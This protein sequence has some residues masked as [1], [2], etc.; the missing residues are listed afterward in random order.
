VRGLATTA[1]EDSSRA[2]GSEARGDG[3]RLRAEDDAEMCAVS[4]RL[5]CK[6]SKCAI[7]IGIRLLRKKGAVAES[8]IKAVNAYDRCV[9][10]KSREEQEVVS[11]A[12][13]LWADIH[14]A[15]AAMTREQ[16]L[17]V[18][19]QVRE[20]Q[21]EERLLWSGVFDLDHMSSAFEQ[22]REQRTDKQTRRDM[23]PLSHPLSHDV[24]DN[25]NHAIRYLIRSLQFC[26]ASGRRTDLTTKLASVYTQLG[27]HYI[28]MGRFTRAH[29]HLQQGTQLFQ[30]IGDE[31]SAASLSFK[32]GRLFAA[33]AHAAPIAA[34]LSA[35]QLTDL[36]KAR[37]L[38]QQA[39][40]TLHALAL[41]PLPAAPARAQKALKDLVSQTQEELADIDMA[42]GVGKLHATGG[43][44]GGGRAGSWVGKTGSSLVVGGGAGAGS[45][46]GEEEVLVEEESADKALLRALATYEALN[47]PQATAAHLHLALYMARVEGEAAAMAQGA[48]NTNGNA[49][50]GRAGALLSD[51]SITSTREQ[52]AAALRAVKTWRQ[53]SERHLQQAAALARTLAE[54]VRVGCIRA[55]L[56]VRRGTLVGLVTA[57]DSLLQLPEM[58]CKAPCRRLQSSSS[59][60]PPRNDGGAAHFGDAMAGVNA[61]LSGE[62]ARWA[63]FDGGWGASVPH[64]EAEA[65]G[66]AGQGS[67]A[68]ED[69]IWS[70]V[71]RQTKAVLLLL[72]RRKPP[73]QE[74]ERCKALFRYAL[75]LSQQHAGKRFMQLLAAH[76]AQVAKTAPRPADKDDDGAEEE[77][78]K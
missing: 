47:L 51:A 33:R 1:E 63:P 60:A 12:M 71:Q 69:A 28:R 44:A 31:Q 42:I 46:A 4:R 3:D 24:E 32:L 34:G 52:R 64:A 58:H 16:V 9:R 20:I 75:E 76:Y 68:E 61:R 56:C 6:A 18:R 74:G 49:A 39:Y 78:D 41:P 25:C 38:V 17:V 45:G 50:S 36:V 10:G 7:A 62:L 72:V 43:A 23:T 8:L 2:S 57:L 40:K 14:V 11:E 19:A 53:R 15:L 30:S 54:S 55:E 22:Q 35:E 67:C 29:Q 13:E 59:P 27:A 26:N 37:A 21:E 48:K 77:N 66:H 5:R 65:Q 73:G 70:G